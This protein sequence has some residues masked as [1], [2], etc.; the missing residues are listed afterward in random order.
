MKI[1]RLNALV[2]IRI[3]SSLW[4]DWSI[5]TKMHLYI[6]EFSWQKVSYHCYRL[7]DILGVGWICRAG[8]IYTKVKM[9]GGS[10]IS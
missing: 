4:T 3:S 9:R 8:R 2:F 1:S 7:T 6:G 5:N 10:I